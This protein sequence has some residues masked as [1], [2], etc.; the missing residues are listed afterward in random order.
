[1]SGKWPITAEKILQQGGAEQQVD[2]CATKE[3]VFS[4]Q[5]GGLS[6]EGEVRRRKVLHFLN[7]IQTGGGGFSNPPSAKSW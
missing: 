3:S 4:K 1:M 5:H 7:P 6:G 2:P